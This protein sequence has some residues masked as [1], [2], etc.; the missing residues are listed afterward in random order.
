MLCVIWYDKTK[1]FCVK[2]NK[3]KQNKT[4]QNKTKR[5][6]GKKTNTKAKG[7]KL[8]GKKS[9]KD[10]FQCEIL[11]IQKN[12]KTLYKRDSITTHIEDNT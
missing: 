10:I 4:K 9:K 12:C 11:F 3:T 8:Q 2:K 1:E 7:E 5:L 6:Q